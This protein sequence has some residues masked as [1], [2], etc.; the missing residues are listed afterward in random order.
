MSIET[1]IKNGQQV[2][3]LLIFILLPSE[4]VAIK[5]LTLED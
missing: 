1:P 3:E 2:N 4:I 5:L